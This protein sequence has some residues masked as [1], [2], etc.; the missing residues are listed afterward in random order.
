M[1]LLCCKNKE[2]ACGYLFFILAALALDVLAGVHI[3]FIN[4]IEF[5]SSEHSKEKVYEVHTLSGLIW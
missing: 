2:L 5:G 1:A 4:S 3:G